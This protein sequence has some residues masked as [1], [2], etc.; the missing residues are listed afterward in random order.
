MFDRFMYRFLGGI[1]N[2]FLKIENLFTKKRRKNEK[3]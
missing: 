2:L 3:M 1:D